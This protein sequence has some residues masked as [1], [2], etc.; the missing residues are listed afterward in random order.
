MTYYLLKL[1]LSAGIIVLV[2]EI[3]KVNAALGAL[4]KFLPLVSVLA[5]FWLYWALTT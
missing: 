5:I 3:A 1:F 4:I 2:S